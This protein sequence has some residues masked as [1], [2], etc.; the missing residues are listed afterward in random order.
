MN[1]GT[2]PLGHVIALFDEARRLCDEATRRRA[3][4]DPD[5]RAVAALVAQAQVLA[6]DVA[7]Y[8]LPSGLRLS[9]NAFLATLDQRADATGS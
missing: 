6:E 8:S 5:V 4:G 1:P 2:L 9:V 3:A 7:S